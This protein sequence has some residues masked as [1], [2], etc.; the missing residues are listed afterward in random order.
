M[1]EGRVDVWVSDGWGRG[2]RSS[3]NFRQE[4]TSV[5]LSKLGSEFDFV[6]CKN[7]QWLPL[8]VLYKNL[9]Y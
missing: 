2:T 8:I 4:G 7:T 6:F 3:P 9:V 1:W 5:I